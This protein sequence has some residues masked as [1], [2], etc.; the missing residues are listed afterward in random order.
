MFAITP[1]ELL[2]SV[3]HVF[4]AK[5][6]CAAEHEPDMQ[7]CVCL[8][9]PLQL[10]DCNMAS[11]AEW[12]IA[13]KVKFPERDDCYDFISHLPSSADHTSCTVYHNFWTENHPCSN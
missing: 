1:I 5:T 13:V 4:K 11:K 6:R 8:F 12:N 9:L 3:M 7:F 2:T 10:S